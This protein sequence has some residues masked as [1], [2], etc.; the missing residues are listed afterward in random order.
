[1]RGAPAGPGASAT[2]DADPERP[3]AL[4][5]KTA[6]PARR[7]PIRFE[8]AA[9]VTATSRRLGFSQEP[10]LTDSSLVTNP[11]PGLRVEAEAATV[12][13]PG[14]GLAVSYERSMGA[15]VAL[16]GPDQVELPVAQK[17]WGFDLRGR[18]RLHKRWVPMVSVGYSELSYEVDL[19]PA[20]L[21]VP[22]AHYAFLGIGGGV[23]Y[24]VGALAAFGLARYLHTM[25]TTGITDMNSFGP[26]GSYGLSG[27]AGV[28][29]ALTDAVLLRGGFRYQRF[30]FHFNGEG[31]LAVALDDDLDQDVVG[32]T[33]AYLGG[34]AEAAYRF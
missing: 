27:E 28:E 8:A 11:S 16:G 24:E 7:F 18:M 6:P 17:Q 19:R 26:A 21:L 13:E 15:H 31:E 3:A 12:A 2:A 32:A 9:G 5:Q 22:D 4:A 30:A 33:D 23:R 10:G 34:F 20:G 25:A 29:V 1:V 14:V